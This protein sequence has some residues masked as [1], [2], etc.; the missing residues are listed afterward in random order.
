VNKPRREKEKILTFLIPLDQ[1]IH[2]KRAF[3]GELADDRFQSGGEVGVSG[4][5]TSH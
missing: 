5:S 2:V 3:F 1:F 4:G